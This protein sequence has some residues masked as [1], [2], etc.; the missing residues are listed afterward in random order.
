MLDDVPGH[1]AEEELPIVAV[2]IGTH[3]DE[4]CPAGAG[5]G[6]QADGDRSRGIFDRRLPYHEPLQPKP[7]EALQKW[8]D[9]CLAKRNR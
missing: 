3:D 6:E 1:S 5:V 7:D 2:G 4:A 8:I 9:E